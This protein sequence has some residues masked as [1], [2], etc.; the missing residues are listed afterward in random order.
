MKGMPENADLCYL[1]ELA[2][3]EKSGLSPGR[4]TTDARSSRKR[5]IRK[6]S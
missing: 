3:S 2:S 6:Y 4:E 1:K 5:K